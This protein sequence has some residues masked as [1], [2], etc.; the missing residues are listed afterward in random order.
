MANK[1]SLCNWMLPS[2][3]SKRALVSNSSFA[4]CVH[5]RIKVI[6]LFRQKKK[7]LIPPV[8]QVRIDIER[9]YAILLTYP[10]LTPASHKLPVLLRAIFQY[11]RQ[12]FF[13]YVQLGHPSMFTRER[14]RASCFYGNT[15]LRLD[16]LV[17]PFQWQRTVLWK[18]FKQKIRIVY[19]RCLKFVPQR[20]LQVTR[21]WP[22][23]CLTLT[24]LRAPLEQAGALQPTAFHRSC[25]CL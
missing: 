8:Q 16:Y 6:S 25:S 18:F 7:S 11:L 23:C 1:N 20:R 9:F 21:E 10:S 24:L 4:I 14:S 13:R 22:A 5:V 19:I 15:S 2:P 3:S 12:A 17:P